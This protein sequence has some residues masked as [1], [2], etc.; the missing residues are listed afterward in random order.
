MHLVAKNDP[1]GS[2]CLVSVCKYVNIYFFFN[3]SSA[4]QN[5]LGDSTLG[6]SHLVD[7][8][9][10]LILRQSFSGQKNPRRVRS[11][12]NEVGTAE[13]GRS[14]PYVYIYYATQT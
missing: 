13:Y 3:F 5:C 11:F 10:L 1:L 12:S 7:A 9:R 14:T 8:T 6:S 4:A 2:I